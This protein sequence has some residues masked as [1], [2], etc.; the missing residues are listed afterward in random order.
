MNLFFSFFDPPPKTV[1]DDPYGHND[2]RDEEGDEFDE[3]EMDQGIDEEG[4]EDGLGETVPVIGSLSREDWEEFGE[5]IDF[6][7][8]QHERE[9]ALHVKNTRRSTAGGIWDSTDKDM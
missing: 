1:E 8:E 5:G 9:R 2:Y 3:Y 7:W 4:E 6:D